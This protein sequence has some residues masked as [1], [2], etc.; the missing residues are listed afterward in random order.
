MNTIQ[1]QL[2]FEQ[3]ILR[4]FRIEREDSALKKG[5]RLFSRMVA[6]MQDDFFTCVDTGTF[7]ERCARLQEL[8]NPK[9]TEYTWQIKLYLSDHIYIQLVEQHSEIFLTEKSVSLYNRT[10]LV[11]YFNSGPIQN[12]QNIIL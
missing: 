1:D 12:N 10:E 4:R 9:A 3:R 5:K 7:K 11:K 6:K 8:Y 2:S